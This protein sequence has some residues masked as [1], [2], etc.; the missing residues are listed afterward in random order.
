VTDERA[1]IMCG[2]AGSRYWRRALDKHL[3]A[4]FEQK[5]FTFLVTY[6]QFPD[7]FAEAHA[8]AVFNRLPPIFHENIARETYG[9][10]P[11]DEL[12]VV[13]SEFALDFLKYV[14]ERWLEKDWD[15]LGFYKL[16]EKFGGYKKYRVELIHLL[17]YMRI[18]GRFDDAFYEAVE[19][20]SPAEANSIDATFSP[21]EVYF[22]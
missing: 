21:A 12:Y 9:D 20:N 8:F 4:A 18:D 11:F 22:A 5:R 10:D 1:S 14:D 16:E 17:E 7:K 2:S 19:A 15:A 13:N 3:V 6:L